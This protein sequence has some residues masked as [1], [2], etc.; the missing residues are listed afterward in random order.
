MNNL[1]LCLAL[2]EFF[3]LILRREYLRVSHRSIVLNKIVYFLYKWTLL[4]LKYS[5]FVT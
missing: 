4:N 1:A 5:L 2:I 3:T